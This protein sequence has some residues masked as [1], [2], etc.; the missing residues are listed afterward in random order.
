MTPE[1]GEISIRVVDGMKEIDGRDWDSLARSPAYSPFLEYDFLAAAEDSGCAVPETGWYPRHFLATS[2]DRLIGAAPAYAKTHS[3]GEFIYDQGLAAAAADMGSPYYP[4]L[5]AALP[6][7]PS[8]GYRFLVH[9]EHDERVVTDVLL[10]AMAAYRDA[11]G[12]SSHSILFADPAWVE[13]LEAAASANGENGVD[14]G[15]GSDSAAP[16]SGPFL[17]W[18]HQ[19]FL[20]EN[21]GYRDFDGYV[22]AFDKNQRRNILRERASVAQAGIRVETLEGDAITPDILAAMYRFYLSTNEA[23][24]PWAALF[25]NEDWFLNIGRRWKDRLVIFAAFEDGSDEPAAMSMLVRKGEGLYGRY[26][27]TGRFIRNL[28]F[29]LCYYA[30]IEFAVLRGIRWFDPGMG[31]PHKARRGFGSREFVS[32]HSFVDRRI[33]ELFG[34]V[35]PETN[36]AERDMIRQMDAAVPWKALRGHHMDSLS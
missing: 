21:P 15:S 16:A 11:A 36:R 9:P 30:P 17:R 8:P 28:H 22:A 3:M 32:Y 13:T 24:G 18:V 35:L 26:W 19:Y 7:T 6:F 4:K 29:E 1:S 2:G 5:V 31:S 33:S 25:L 23:F 12:F 34:A 10:R 14:N 27:G 20:W